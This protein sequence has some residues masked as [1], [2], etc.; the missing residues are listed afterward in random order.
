[1][2]KFENLKIKEI[3][4]YDD[5]NKFNY[6]YSVVVRIDGLIIKQTESRCDI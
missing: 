3:N 5:V 4:N 1:M 2:S 6:P